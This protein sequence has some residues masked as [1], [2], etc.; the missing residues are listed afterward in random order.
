MIDL[1]IK[2]RIITKKYVVSVTV[3]NKIDFTAYWLPRDQPP[4]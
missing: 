2:L 1:K 4:G 3:S